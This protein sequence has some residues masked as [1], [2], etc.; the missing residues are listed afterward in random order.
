MSDSWHQPREFFAALHGEAEH[1]LGAPAKSQLDVGIDFYSDLVTR[2]LHRP[3]RNLTERPQAIRWFEPGLGWQSLSLL[4]LDGQAS[5]LASVLVA[6]G[7]HAGMRLALVLPSGGALLVGL[8]AALSIG[9]VAVPVLPLGGT[10]V[11]RVMERSAADRVLTCSPYTALRGILDYK[12]LVMSSALLAKA[13]KRPQPATYPPES[14]ALLI[15]SPLQGPE[16]L[17][18]L[19]AAET[20]SAA[21]R[22]GLLLFGLRPGDVLAAPNNAQ[23]V[24][25][26]YLAALLCG[27]GVLD[28]SGEAVQSDVS[29][30]LAAPPRAVILPQTIRDALLDAGCGPVNWGSWFR[31]PQ[32]GFDLANWQRA[33][34]QLRLSAVPSANLLWDAASGG[35][36]LVSMPRRGPPQPFLWPAPGCRHCLA[37][38]VGDA[39]AVTDVGRLVL[40]NSDGTLRNS[41]GEALLLRTDNGYMYGGTAQ[42]RRAGWSYPSL[43]V[44]GVLERSRELEWLSGVAVVELAGAGG[45]GQALVVV[46]IFTGSEPV[47]RVQR[48]QCFA[49]IERELG[50]SVRPNQLEVFALH[51]RRLGGA[52]AP[53]DSDWVR[54]QY[55]G[56]DLY[57]KARSPLFQALTHVRTALLRLHGMI[58][59]AAP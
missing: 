57:H 34:E 31:D 16:A 38:L 5:A 10:Y 47:S 54:G 4:Q 28:M 42:P 17:T 53:I 27:A 44:A 49:I 45:A 21:L 23:Y 6:S 29:P 37:E 9:C 1:A 36:V 11:Q 52:S 39:P 46:V 35:A 7:M 55:I 24:P 30:L 8:L 40:Q 20:Y 43:A 2:Y 15:A 12:P 50:P 19:S 33:D 3:D 51:P 58:G 41:P 26:T 14:A 25:C 59:D 13:G 18:M 56:S 48:E 32:E 22:D